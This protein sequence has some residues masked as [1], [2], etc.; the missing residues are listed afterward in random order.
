MKAD[1]SWSGRKLAALVNG[2]SPAPSGIVDQS[3]DFFCPPDKALQFVAY[4]IVN[5]NFAVEAHRDEVSNSEI[6]IQRVPYLVT[7]RL[8]S[9]TR[10][11]KA[12]G[13]TKINIIAGYE[14]QGRVPTLWP[15]LF[16]LRGNPILVINIAFER[17]VDDIFRYRHVGQRGGLEISDVG[18]ITLRRPRPVSPTPTAPSSPL[19]DTTD[20]AV[21][22]FDD[23]PVPRDD[24][25]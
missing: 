20:I 18:S 13:V 7:A 9:I 15:S 17:G 3:F 10:M 14:F 1:L 22:L 11:L 12:D 2:A 8:Q 25:S 23:G 6:A 5:C 16:Y 21:L 4:L 19:S 24:E